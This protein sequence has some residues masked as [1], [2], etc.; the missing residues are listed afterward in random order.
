MNGM[1]RSNAHATLTFNYRTIRT[2][3]IPRFKNIFF[4]VL[5]TQGRF[6]GYNLLYNFSFPSIFNRS[7]RADYTYIYIL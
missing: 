6:N 3:L 4:I 2:L 5:W 1:R 7:T